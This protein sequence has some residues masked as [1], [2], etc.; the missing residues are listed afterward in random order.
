MDLSKL[1]YCNTV[2]SGSMTAAKLK[3]VVWQTRVTETITNS[4]ATYGYESKV[5]VIFSPNGFGDK[6]VK[7][8]ISSL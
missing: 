1:S 3:A 6:V 7:S 4:L 8:A 5:T 2:R